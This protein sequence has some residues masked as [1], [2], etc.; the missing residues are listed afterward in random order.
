MKI[1]LKIFSS[2]LIL[3]LLTIAVL[4]FFLM[5]KINRLMTGGIEEVWPG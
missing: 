4:D 2:Y 1:F 5:P 3:I